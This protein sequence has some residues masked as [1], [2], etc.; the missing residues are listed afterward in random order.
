MIQCCLQALVQRK[1]P[2]SLDGPL[3]LPCAHQQLDAVA[4]Y[5]GCRRGFTGVDGKCKET[6]GGG[7]RPAAMI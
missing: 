5:G 1:S 7:T 2:P 3:S 4:F 6:N